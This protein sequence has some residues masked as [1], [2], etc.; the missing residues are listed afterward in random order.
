MAAPSPLH[1]E[2]PTLSDL[3]ANAGNSGRLTTNKIDSLPNPWPINDQYPYLYTR[4][5][6]GMEYAQLRH[7][8]VVN[9]VGSRGQTGLA[10]SSSILFFASHAKGTMSSRII[11][12]DYHQEARLWMATS[13]VNGSRY[14]V[15]GRSVK[16]VLREFCELLE[17]PSRRWTIVRTDERHLL[18][19]ELPDPVTAEPPITAEIPAFQ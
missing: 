16:E 14:C 5:G 10:G 15:Q 19:Q 3:Q 8:S 6:F 17:Q 12:F 18:C 7:F 9:G 11:R 2:R 4:Q 13:T 1:G